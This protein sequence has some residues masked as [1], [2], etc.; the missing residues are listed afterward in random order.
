MTPEPV[1]SRS[2]RRWLIAAAILSV[3]AAMVALAVWWVRDGNAAIARQS[4]QP[5]PSPVLSS[6]MRV[7][8]VAGWRA[9]VTDLGLPGPVDG[10]EGTE[11]TRI[12]TLK[13]P[14]RSRPLIGNVG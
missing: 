2:R 3:V 13:D 14:V 5:P 4:W 11:P 7:Q 6:P 9:N 10:T 12:G 1:A 8:P